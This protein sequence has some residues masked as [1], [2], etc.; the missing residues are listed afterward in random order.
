MKI[1]RRSFLKICGASTA[2]LGL[3]LTDLTRLEQ[4]LANPSGPTVVWLQGSGCT[5]CSISFLNRIAATG[6]HTAGDVLIDAINL[7]Y[8]PNLMSLAGDSAV[9]RI[10]QAYTE[11]GYILAVEGGIPT[12][13]DGNA[14][15]AW[16][17]ND[18]DV[19]FQQAVLDLASQA[20]HIL[21]IGTCASWGGVAAAPPNPT[22]VQGL[23]ALTGRTTINIAGCP[24]HPDWIV[25]TI[26]QLLVGNTVALDSKGRPTGLFNR[27]V[28]SVCPR[29]ESDEAGTYGIDRRCLEELGCQGPHTTAPCPHTLWNGGVNWCVDA[30]APC[31][32]C[33]EP[34]FPGAVSLYSGGGGEGRDDED[35]HEEDDD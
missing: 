24:P 15:W 34:G 33:T 1:S 23:S 14:C 25:W 6:P 12:A 28:H 5:G 3:S 13:F 16:T 32:G 30:N 4:V 26:A 9:A 29:R 27:T 35:D 10:E 7:T 31:Y 20:A 19:T 22:M 2:A 18:I 21:S 11:G 8:H 17:Y